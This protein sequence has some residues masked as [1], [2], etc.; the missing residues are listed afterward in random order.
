M[1]I[2]VLFIHN[3]T[4]CHWYGFVDRSKGVYSV[5]MTA[6]RAYSIRDSTMYWA[7][8]TRI[9]LEWTVVPLRKVSENVDSSP[10]PA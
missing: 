6:R 7:P 8:I 10:D 2:P 1:L 3:R 9:S 4:G 5:E